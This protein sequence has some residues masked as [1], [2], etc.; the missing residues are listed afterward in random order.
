MAHE[1]LMEVLRDTQNL[2][3]FCWIISLVLNFI[4]ILLLVSLSQK[5]NDAREGE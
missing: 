1:T 3:V 2:I 4:L 5:V